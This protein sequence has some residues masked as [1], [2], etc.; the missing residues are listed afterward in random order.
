M[1][2]YYNGFRLRQTDGVTVLGVLKSEGFEPVVTAIKQGM[3][4]TAEGLLME[5]EADSAA[6]MN[7]YTAEENRCI[8]MAIEEC[9]KRIEWLYADQKGC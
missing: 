4:A 1:G 6:T 7:E 5:I 2:K 8:D 3:P 9:W